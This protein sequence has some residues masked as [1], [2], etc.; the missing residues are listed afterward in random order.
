M[1]P[2]QA[3][4]EAVDARGD[5]YALGV[6]L[7]E[8]L[9]G[10]Q[11]FVAG[12]AADLVRQQREAPVPQLSAAALTQLV[13]PE[14][15]N[16]VMARALSKDPGRRYPTAGVLADA[17]RSMF[18]E[19]PTAPASIPTVP[20]L[21]EDEAPDPAAAT[22]PPPPPTLVAFEP[23]GRE[24]AT[25]LRA[26]PTYSPPAP[27]RL[28]MLTVGLGGG[29]LA[30]VI[31]LLA[32]ARWMNLGGWGLPPTPTSTATA[33][34]TATFTPTP[35]P[36]STPTSTPSATLTP[37]PT[38]TATASDTPTRRPTATRTLSPTATNTRPPTQPPF[39][40]T[41]TST[42]AGAAPLPLPATAT[43]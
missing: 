30:L 1:S 39:T 22:I 36:T 11:P 24:P 31:L 4:G 41:A 5:V 38:P 23:T 18:L 27:P 29:G 9:T 26:G 20:A 35:V 10:R 7:F 12:T 14:E 25:I 42:I 28:S 32:L 43:P 21:P 6:I 13:L 40:P 33:T 8:M 37:S 15:F 2:E 3:A 34:A 17:M 19:A 16:Q